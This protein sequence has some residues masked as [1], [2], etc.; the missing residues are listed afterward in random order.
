MTD[1]AFPTFHICGKPFSFDDLTYREKHE[2]LK[3]LRQLA[4]DPH[5]EFGMVDLMFSTPALIYVA[6]KRT[7]GA[8]TVD[9]ALDSKDE[10]YFKVPDEKRPTRRKTPTA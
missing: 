10:E 6:R 3:I 7:D 1:E 4:D 2:A 5:A 9:M 8:F